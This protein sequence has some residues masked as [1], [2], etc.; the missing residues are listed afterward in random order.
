MPQYV[1]CHTELFDPMVHC[2]LWPEY[3]DSPDRQHCVAFLSVLPGL[4]TEGIMRGFSSS[5]FWLVVWMNQYV[6]D[7]VQVSL[8]YILALHT[9]M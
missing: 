9:F 5:L 4:Q 6:D 8:C 3:R 7:A 1:T 2:S